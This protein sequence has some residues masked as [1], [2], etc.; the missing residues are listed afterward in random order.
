[1]AEVIATQTVLADSQEKTRPHFSTY[2]M[3]DANAG[4]HSV[5]QIE[6]KRRL[7]HMKFPSLRGRHDVD[8]FQTELQDKAFKKWNDDGD[9]HAEAPYRSCDNIIDP[10]SGFVSAGGDADRN[11]GHDRIRSLVQLN[12]TPQS[13]APASQH[14][15]RSKEPAAPPE[16]RRE[17]TWSPGAPTAWNSRKT[18]D[19][20][21]R[22]QLGGWTSDHDP[23]K[24]APELTRS[25]SMYIA[26]PPSETS[27]T[28]RDHLALQYMYSPTTQRS[29]AEVPWDSMLA[30]KI[31]PPIST[32]ENKPDQ[33]S[34][35]WGNKKYDPAAQEWQNTGRAWDWFQRRHGHYKTQPINFASPCP[36]VQQIPLYGGCIGAEN[37]EEV[38]NPAEPFQ[39][40]TIKRVSLPRSADT[41]HRPNIPGYKG[42]TL[43]QGHYAPANTHPPP[44]PSIQPMTSLIHKP[45]PSPQVS[46]AR[47]EAEMSRM[48]TLVPPCNPFN[49]IDKHEVVS[50]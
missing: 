33:I 49:T 38:D 32:A 4:G 48:V 47:R 15:V 13:S 6:A 8:S 10:V 5:A 12:R 17:N 28:S 1:M 2:L 14:S 46:G 45:F 11:T 35:R 31:W 37:L 23:R 36:R 30:P 9:H 18:S 7:R 16:L 44:E 50:A 19:I 27:K 40:F 25:K 24:P 39:P 43:W 3:T 22:S 34:H 20:W 42:C 29:Y 41:A 26:K 21:I